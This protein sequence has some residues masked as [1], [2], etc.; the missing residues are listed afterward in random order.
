M[1]TGPA[2]HVAHCSCWKRSLWC[3]SYRLI[4]VRAL[5]CGL[6]YV[7]FPLR[8]SCG[9]GFSDVLTA[10]GPLVSGSHFSRL[11]AS[12]VLLCGVFWEIP[13]GN[14]PVSCAIWFDS[15]YSLRQF[16]VS[17]RQQRQVRTVQTVPGPARG[18]PTRCRSWLCYQHDHC[19]ASQG[20]RHHRRGAEAVS[21]G[22]VSRS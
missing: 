12:R 17:V 19:C 5:R 11:V 8:L 16:T 18:D 2:I 15:G 9:D 3:S 21:L 13:S 20:R 7:Q 22:P 10:Y 14:V 4:G 1:V 6:D